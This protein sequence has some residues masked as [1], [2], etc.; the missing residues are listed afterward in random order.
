MKKILIT[1]LL[2]LS[3]SVGAL[4]STVSVFA[5]TLPNI[6]EIN[7]NGTTIEISIDS[8]DIKK[9]IVEYTFVSNDILMSKLEQFEVIPISC[10]IGS[11]IN[12][13]QI[14]VPKQALS[15]KIWRVI[16]T[17]DQ[18]KSLNGTLEWIN[19][20]EDAISAVETRIKTIYVDNK[21]VTRES[22][23]ILIAGGAGGVI[24]GYTFHMHFNL[25][26]AE[27]N[28]IPIDYLYSLN[29]EFDVIKVPFWGLGNKKSTHESYILKAGETRNMD[30]WPFLAPYTVNDEL[31]KSF[32]NDYEF[33]ITL[34][35]YESDKL[36]SLII[37]LD[38]ISLLTVSYFYNGVFYDSETVQDEPYSS[39]DVIDVY[40][41]TID[42]ISGILNQI[43]ALKDFMQNLS[44]SFR[45][46]IIIAI[47]ILGLMII[48]F[49]SKI[50]SL[51]FKI[52]FI[53]Y[54]IVRSFIGIIKMLGNFFYFLIK[55]IINIPGHLINILLFLFIPKN[56]KKERNSSVS[57]YI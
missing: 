36:N 31:S 22:E 15:I 44:S 9:A 14:N 35:S 6:S 27:G 24:P 30:T 57:K 39:D 1:I 12:I 20:P 55:F 51:I 50:I 43:G 21:L 56:K 33:M 52:P 10:E 8:G 49:A 37:Q 25:N 45:T 5:D 17:N 4:A 3:T 41:G 46:T 54:K 42:E 48:S 18:I 19:T 28:A 11:N 38:N 34:G 29:V 53:I 32:D 2:I 40:P 13:Y 47:L 26:D 23:A 16:N 7:K